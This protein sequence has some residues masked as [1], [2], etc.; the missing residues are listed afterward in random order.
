MLNEGYYG[1]DDLA[2][3]IAGHVKSHLAAYEYPRVVR[4]ITE[5][6]MTTTGKIIRAT[7]RR[8]AEDEAAME[9]QQAEEQK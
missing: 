8:M 7:L 1:S 3:E 9:R 2:A 5:M 4:F 6:P